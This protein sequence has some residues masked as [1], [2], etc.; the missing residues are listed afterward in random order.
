MDTMTLTKEQMELKLLK[1]LHGM[2]MK[3]DTYLT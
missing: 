1:L 3:W 2:T